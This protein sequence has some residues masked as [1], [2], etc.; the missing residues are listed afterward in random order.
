M[1]KLQTHIY[2]AM[3]KFWKNTYGIVDNITSPKEDLSSDTAG[4]HFLLHNFLYYLDSFYC[5]NILFNFWR[6]NNDMPWLSAYHVSNTVMCF[7][8]TISK[9][10]NS[11][12]VVV[13]F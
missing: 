2:I 10:H 5:M 7:I 9:P 13:F 3:A 11:Y 6:R 4:G 12:E 1:K 8:N